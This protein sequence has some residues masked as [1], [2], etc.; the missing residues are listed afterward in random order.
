MTVLF[1]GSFHPPTNGHIDIIQTAAGM[2]DKVIAAILVNAGKRYTISAEERLSM[3]KRCISGIP[4]AEAVI[5]SGLTAAFAKEQ[6]AD[7]LV[8]GV[9]STADFEY[10]LQIADVNRK[11]YGIET[12]FLPTKPELSFVA[13]SIVMDI[14]RHGGDIGGFVP[15]IIQKDIFACI[16]R[17]IKGE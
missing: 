15:S 10:E 3:L 14:A 8:R 2:F 5:G 6:G 4:N 7:A 12:I 16:E 17:E 9:R 11:L 1:A 13:S